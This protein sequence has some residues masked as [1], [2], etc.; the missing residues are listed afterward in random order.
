MPPSFT[1]VNPG[2]LSN[3][4]L[5]TATW[6]LKWTLESGLLPLMLEHGGDP[7][8]AIYW[9]PLSDATPIWMNFVLLCFCISPDSPY[10][11]LYLQVLD[12]FIA[13]DVDMRIAIS[14]PSLDCSQSQ[15][16]TGL[17]LFL[18]HLPQ[19]SADVYSRMN[20]HLLTEV[21]KRLLIMAKITSKEMHN[22]WP[23]L[24]NAF[25]SQTISHF[26]RRLLRAGSETRCWSPRAS[27]QMQ[28]RILA[29]DQ[30]DGMSRKRLRSVRPGMNNEDAVAARPHS[31][32]GESRLLPF[33]VPIV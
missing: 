25:P 23:I 19:T 2:S 21:V 32:S 33:E 20:H 6:K 22:Y 29:D 17:D 30:D 7:N 26:R 9:Q 28:K 8:V 3:R 27:T 24:E 15:N 18:D 11:A 13:A 10:R 12:F 31:T 14:S 1:L 16:V 5:D 4:V